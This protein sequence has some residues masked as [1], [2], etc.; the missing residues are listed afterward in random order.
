MAEPLV[1]QHPLGI[2]LMYEASPGFAK[3][4]KA[5]DCPRLRHR[6]GALGQA[7]RNPELLGRLGLP[8]GAPPEKVRAALNKKD[9]D[10]D[11]PIH[12]AL[13]DEGTGPELIRAMLDAGGE[14]MLAVS[15]KAKCLPLHWAARFSPSPAVVAL[16]LAR[17]SAGALRAKDGG[18]YTPLAL[19]E[20]HNRGPAAAE[21]AALLRAA[22]Q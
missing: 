10:G 15:G 14:A 2:Q 19:A 20:R 13:Y 22:M 8:A 16:L 1:S 4:E 9:G 6:G 17:G 5:A 3:S 18:G 12:D 11:L 7:A 21:I